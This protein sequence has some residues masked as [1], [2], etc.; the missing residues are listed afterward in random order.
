MRRALPAVVITV[1][2]SRPRSRRSSRPR[3]VGDGHRPRRRVARPAP[4]ATA[5]TP[6]TTPPAAPRR[7]R[8]R[9][10]RRRRP[11]PPTTRRRA[12]T[13]RARSTA[14]RST[15]G[16][17]RCRCAS[18]C[19]AG[20]SPTSPRCR[21]RT[22]TSARSTS[23]SRP[24][25]YLQ[26]EALQ[27]QSAQIDIV[28][29]ATYTSESYAQ[30]LQ[31]ALDKAGTVVTQSRDAAV[32]RVEEMWGTVISVDVRDRD[33][34]RASSTTASRGSAA[35]TTCSARGAPTPRSCASGAAS[36]RVDDASPEVREVLDAVRADAASSRTAR[37]TSRSARVP[38]CRRGPGSRRSTRRDS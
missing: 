25:R 1:D 9:H 15:T 34:R 2:R 16:T 22:T 32:R 33:R 17:A 8:R 7:P 29:G 37:S 31:S 4:P 28:S 5:A 36:S 21:C 3:R 26:Q 20:R 11:P 23:A 12:S 10:R 35:S 18:R 27:A 38:T 19:R 14:T 13:R 24:G 6:T 30:S